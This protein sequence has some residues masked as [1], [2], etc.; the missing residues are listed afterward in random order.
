MS[1][2]LREI[3]HHRAMLKFYRG[4]RRR[5]MNRLAHVLWRLCLLIMAWWLAE[6]VFDIW[7]A[8]YA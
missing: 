4:E 2:A 6:T 7:E 5:R 3:R 1:D 8:W